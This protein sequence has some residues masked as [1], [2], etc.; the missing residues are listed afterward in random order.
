MDANGLGIDDQ[1]RDDLGTL[2]GKQIL[3]RGPGA[4]RYALRRSGWSI[5][6]PG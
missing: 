5:L 4:A 1:R 6:R 2:L 3:E